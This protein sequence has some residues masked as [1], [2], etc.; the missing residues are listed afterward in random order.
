MQKTLSATDAAGIADPGSGG[1]GPSGGRRLEASGRTTLGQLNG[2]RGIAVFGPLVSHWCSPD[3]FLRINFPMFD[4]L[5]FFFLLSGFLITKILLGCRNESEAQS[6]T[7]GRLLRR[8]FIRRALRTFPVYYVTLLV[9][10]LI[11]LPQMIEQLPWNLVYLSNYY[12]MFHPELS[13]GSHFWTLAIQEQFYL[14]WAFAILYLSRRS[15]ARLLPVLIVLAPVLRIAARSWGLSFLEFLPFAAFDTF[16]MGALLGL[17]G[18]PRS[19]LGAARPFLT[20]AGLGVGLPAYLCLLWA[21]AGGE[22][23]GVSYTLIYPFHRLMAAWFFLWLVDAADRGFSGLAGWLFESPALSYVGTISYGIYVLHPFTAPFMRLAIGY[24]DLG[25]DLLQ[26]T[27][28]FSV[29]LAGTLAAASLSW[30]LMEKPI[31]RLKRLFPYR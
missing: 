29:K 22:I 4:A 24:F 9:T 6:G 12:F 7:R 17:A 13:L 3:H 10:A 28:W 18:D 25:P 20:R 30:Y 1:R 11:A 26:S 19:P 8:F 14:L 31:G 5:T 15:V 21:R 23:F 2:L 27:Y 16:G